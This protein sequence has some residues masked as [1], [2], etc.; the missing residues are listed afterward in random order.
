MYPVIF[1]YMWIKHSYK[2]IAAVLLAQTCQVSIS[3]ILL[4]SCQWARHDNLNRSIWEFS[5]SIFQKEIQLKKQSQLLSHSMMNINSISATSQ[6]YQFGWKRQ[7]KK[8]TVC[9]SVAKWIRNHGNETR[10]EGHIN[11]LG[12]YQRSNIFPVRYKQ[13]Y[14]VELSFN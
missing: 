14:R 1:I 10:S 2:H 11:L 13:T 7:A 3:V 5:S 12:Y 4:V 9:S 6:C 8:I